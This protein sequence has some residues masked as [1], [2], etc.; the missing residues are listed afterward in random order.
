MRRDI[1]G[2]H[3][4]PH[5]GRHVRNKRRVRLCKIELDRLRI[6]DFYRSPGEV[7]IDR[8]LRIILADAERL[9]ELPC[10]LEDPGCGGSRRKER[11]DPDRVVEE[12]SPVEENLTALASN[13]LPSWNLIPLRSLKT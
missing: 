8:R 11:A 13:A 12:H 2:G 6:D 7:L 3:D 10:P 5:E 4:R 9:A 1:G